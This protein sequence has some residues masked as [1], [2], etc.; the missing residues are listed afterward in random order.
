MRNAQISWSWNAPAQNTKSFFATV[1]EEIGAYGLDQVGIQELLAL[2]IGPKADASFCQEL[3]SMPPARMLTLSNREM[4][5][6]GAASGAATRLEAV[7]RLAK[8]LQAAGARGGA[9]NSS[10]DAANAFSF[11]A[12]EEEEHVVVLLLDTKNNVRKKLVASKGTI[13]ASLVHPREVFKAAVRESACSIV[14][15][16]NHPSGDPTPSQDDIGVT[17]RI[18]EAGKLLGIQVLDHIVVST[19]GYRSLKE[20]GVF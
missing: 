5:Q 10:A 13:N 15:G 3:A 12:N 17:K 2:I 18:A 7:F 14:L 4:R 6:M 19:N 9:V 16:H 11:I 1:Q 20:M 8:K